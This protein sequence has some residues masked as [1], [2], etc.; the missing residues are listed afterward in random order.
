MEDQTNQLQKA[1]VT[2]AAAEP[3]AI[4]GIGC[5][6]LGGGNDPYSYWSMMCSEKDTVS[7]IPADRWNVDKFYDPEGVKPGTTQIRFGSFLKEID[8]F[9]ARFFDISPRE[10]AVMDPQQRMMM[11]VVWEAIED[12]GRPPESLA[13][14][15]TGV[16]VGVFAQDQMMSAFSE[17]E[18]ELL[19]PHSGVGA[20]MSIVANRVSF[21]FDFKGPSLGLD[22]AC[23]SSLVA[24]HLG[25]QSLWSGETDSVIAGGVN[26]IFK[27]EWTIG[28]SRGG[29]LSVDGR[30][31]S[32]DASANGYVRGEGAGAVLMKR[33]S[34]A[35]RDGDRI[36]ALIRG[37]GSNQDGHTPG[38]TLPN[39]ESQKALMHEVYQNA[40]VA[41][42]RIQ[43][44]EAH[45]TGTVAGDPVEANSIGSILSTDRPEGDF[46]LMGSVKSNMGHLEAAAGIAGLIKATLCL[47]HGKI[48]ANIHLKNLNPAIDLE[49]LKLRIP[50]QMV[51]YPGLIGNRFAGVNSFGFGGT[52]AHAVLAD[53]AQAYADHDFDTSL[54]GDSNGSLSKSGPWLIPFSAKT[55]EALSDV[56]QANIDFLN[57]TQPDLY[58]FGYASSLRKGRHR[59]RAAVVAETLPELT[60]KMGSFLE[61]KTRAG[62]VSGE[63]SEAL[64]GPVFVF[65]GMGPQ[66]WAMG[67][68]L[69][70]SEPVFRKAVQECDALISKLA[71]WSLW[72]ELTAEES[73]S[74]I[75]ETQ[76]AQPAIFAIQ[77]GLTALWESWGVMPAVIVGH[78]AGEVAAAWAAGALT[79]SDACQVIYQRSRLQHLTEGEGRMMAVGLPADQVA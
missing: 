10:A 17:M 13:N 65:S 35:K 26:A 36:Y 52:N 67:R 45:G 30:C 7:E 25:C 16:F 44:V 18:R 59:Y 8:Q 39:G 49:K 76:I 71:D 73:T 57:T 43:Y 46:C 1:T 53:P 62:L 58:R 79:L 9:D 61:G 3:I 24:T 51:E 63:T 34:D 14:T 33:L 77:V 21:W 19:G 2:S 74:R 32:F 22:T 75:E 27:P 55:P 23:S 6:F 20:S 60:E 12:S 50:T 72:N 37:T 54:S 66:W 38:I 48:P 40:G 31:K 4:V 28:V 5:R 15:R 68:E 78:S 56:V 11:E 69:L 64:K 41:P 47:F 42:H 70:E 29:F